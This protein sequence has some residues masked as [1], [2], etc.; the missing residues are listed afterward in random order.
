MR[1]G[2]GI[3]II[4]TNG[5]SL[6]EQ[7]KE[8]GPSTLFG[9]HVRGF[10]NLLNVGPVQRAIG[11]TWLHTAYATGDQIAATVSQVLH[12]SQYDVIEPSEKA[13]EDWAKKIEEGKREHLK[14]GQSCSPGYNNNEG[15]P[16]EVSPR[17]GYYSGGV[18]VWAS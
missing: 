8:D 5:Q 16:E 3:D 11:L 1:G 4:G 6:D 13:A 18:A 10:P 12:D 14:F 15:K 2:T 9:V 17:W 7:W